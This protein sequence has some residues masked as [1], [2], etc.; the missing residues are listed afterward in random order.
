MPLDPALFIAFLVAAWVLI[1]VPGPDTLFVLGQTLAGGRRRGWAAVGGIV[2]GAMAHVA[3]ATAGVAALFAASPALFTA[4]RVA[5]GAYLLWLGAHA[6]RAAWR[7]E[8]SAP[9]AVAPAT[10]RSARDAFLQG[11][12][13]NL[14]N[15]K[16]AVFFLAFLPQFVAPGRAPAW[17]QMLLMGPL[18][19]LMAVPFFGLVIL[20]ASHARSR[21]IRGGRRAA[22]WLEGVAGGLFLALGLRL[23]VEV[24]GAAP[25]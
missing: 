16:V 13:T 8:G 22:R 9:A 3:A 1:L 20:G 6:L 5:G 25:R 14:L 24:A 10:A 7:G 12:L 18:V 19:P 15:P 4:L 17:V 23:F 11:L 21:L 2:T